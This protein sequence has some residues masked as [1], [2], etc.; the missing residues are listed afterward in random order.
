MNYS[1]L[2]E[3]K[4]ALNLRLQSITKELQTYPKTA[5]GIT[6]PGFQDERYHML[7]CEYKQVWMQFLVVLRELKL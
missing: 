6:L 2:L 1:D 5:N 7:K 3:Q 4:Q